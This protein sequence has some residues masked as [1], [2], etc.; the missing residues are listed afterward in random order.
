MD[1][2]GSENNRVI[3]GFE[4]MLAITAATEVIRARRIP[5]V[6]R[7]PKALCVLT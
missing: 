4:E 6:S 5:A 3:M 1:I 7:L 2:L